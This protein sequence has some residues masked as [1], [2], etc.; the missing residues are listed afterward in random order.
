MINLYLNNSTNSFYVTPLENTNLIFTIFKFI[1]TNRAT[2]DEVELWVTNQSSTYRYQK[3]IINVNTYFANK[4]LGLW[5]Y[6]VY[7]CASIGGTPNSPVLETGYMNL[8][9][10][11][12]FEPIEYNQQNSTFVTYNG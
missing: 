2:N 7:G 9:S 12:T 8:H 10:D 6:E 5:G 11:I 1:F 3:F 4:D